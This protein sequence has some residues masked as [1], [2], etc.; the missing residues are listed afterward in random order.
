MKTLAKL[1]LALVLTIFLSRV[2]VAQPVSDKEYNQFLI[3]SLQ[4][5]NIGIRSSAAQLLGERQVNEAVEPLVKMLT[6]E[7]NSSVRIVVAIALYK[8]GDENALPV[9]KKVAAT[10]KNKTVRKVAGAIVQK[11][12]KAELAQK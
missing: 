7:E 12:E 4:D 2:L 6:T 10:D 3:K 11:F 5:E 1:I 8:I 9:L